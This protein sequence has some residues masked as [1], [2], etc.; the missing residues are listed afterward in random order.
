MA[1]ICE[2]ENI[3]KKIVLPDCLRAMIYNNLTFGEL[4]RMMRLSKKEKEMIHEYAGGTIQPKLINCELK[5]FSNLQKVEFGLD[6]CKV[7]LRISDPILLK[8]SLK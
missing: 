7:N 2:G 3:K 6:L 8:T 1:T 5:D 4:C